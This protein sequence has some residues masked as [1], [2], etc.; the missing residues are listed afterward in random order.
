MAAI[1]GR[2]IGTAGLVVVLGVAAVGG[3]LLRDRFNGRAESRAAITKACEGL[4]D[5]DA[6]MRFAGGERKVEA[7]PPADRV[8]LLSREV[9]FEGED[10]MADFFSLS[11]VASKEA[12][13]GESRFGFT[14]RTVTVTAKCADPVRSK[15]VTALRVTAGAEF[16]AAIRGEPG[17]LPSLAR[18]AALR[19]AVKAGCQTTLPTAP[20]L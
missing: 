2:S 1:R 6:L 16:E 11:V 8:C 7:E 4:V 12:E 10:H 14:A 20:K 5:P 19:A 18:E 17:A 9:T 3:W 15:G 13:P